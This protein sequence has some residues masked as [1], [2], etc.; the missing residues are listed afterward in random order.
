[1]IEQTQNKRVVQEDKNALKVCRL[2]YHVSLTDALHVQTG[3][4]ERN[5]RAVLPLTIL[6]GRTLCL[7]PSSRIARE[8]LEVFCDTWA[9]AVN[10]LSRLAKESD[11]I[12]CGRLV[13]EKQAY[14]SLP[15]PGKHGSTSK[16]AKPVTLDVEDQQK[17]AKV[18]LEMKLLTSEVDA[19]AEKWDEYAE[20]DIVKR[21]K[22]MSSMAF[23]MYLFTRG[24]GPLKTTHDLFTQ[25]EFFAEE[26]NKMYKTVREFSYEVPGSSEKN[27]LMP[28]LERI[29][30]HCQ[31][32]QVLVKSP[33]VGKSATFNKVDSVIQETKNLMNEIAKLVTACFLCATKYDIEFRGTSMSA[34]RTPFANGGDID[35]ATG[36]AT[37][38]F[39]SLGDSS[40]WRRTPSVRRSKSQ[41]RVA[42]A[43]AVSTLVIVKGFWCSTK[44][45][46]ID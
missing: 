2:L 38:S 18:G 10:E 19:E 26:A 40:P 29:P 31:Q 22:N 7:H 13:A 16:P 12:C 4:A 46:S 34:L 39:R 6:A 41:P 42:A 43:N 24:D 23:N 3:H 27:D 28:V 20:N 32:L 15:K 45:H 14:M 33:T 9:E 36:S 21:A 17:I 35:P 25:A 44:D 8:N 30:V 37:G 11:A 1:M 5:L